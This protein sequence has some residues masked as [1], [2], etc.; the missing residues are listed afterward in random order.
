MYVVI[1]GRFL[2]DFPKYKYFKST[3]RFLLWEWKLS[4]LE[5][6]S[7]IAGFWKLQNKLRKGSPYFLWLNIW[8]ANAVQLSCY[9]CIISHNLSY[10]LK[11]KISCGLLVLLAWVCLVLISQFGD[12]FSDSSECL[13]ELEPCSGLSGFGFLVYLETCIL[14]FYFFSFLFPVA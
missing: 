4:S 11:K 10:I 12:G 7:I 13:C 3:D 14:L 2:F 5:F 8:L 6:L 1:L 9:W